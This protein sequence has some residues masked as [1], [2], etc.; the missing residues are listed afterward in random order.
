MVVSEQP[1]LQAADRPPMVLNGPRA[2]T[3]LL[4]LINEIHELASA[5]TIIAKRKDWAS[6]HA[7]LPLIDRESNEFPMQRRKSLQNKDPKGGV[8]VFAMR[9][10]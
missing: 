7:T 10:S 9:L 4:V 1:R 8:H 5:G 2:H 6:V 3:S